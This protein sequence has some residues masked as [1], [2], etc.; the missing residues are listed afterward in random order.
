MPSWREWQ[1]NMVRQGRDRRA[2]D[3][4]LRASPSRLRPRVAS[5]AVLYARAHRS[6]DRV[7][8]LLERLR[9]TRYQIRLAWER[10]K[11]SVSETWLRLRGVRG[12]EQ[13][14]D[15]KYGDWRD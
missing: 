6:G 15:G 11:L 2:D 14:E 10:W 13:A 1:R 8:T 12:A 3:Q 5:L 7:V 4:F 9:E